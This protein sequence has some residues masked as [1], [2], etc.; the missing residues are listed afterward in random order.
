MKI[1]QGYIGNSSSTSYYVITNCNQETDG[2]GGSVAQFKSKFYP[3]YTWNSFARCEMEFKHS[4]TGAQRYVSFEYCRKSVDGSVANP[5]TDISQFG[6]WTA[7]NLVDLI[8]LGIGSHVIEGSAYGSGS[9]VT[10]E[11]I[12]N[13]DPEKWDVVIWVY[14]LQA[15]ASVYAQDAVALRNVTVTS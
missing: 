14:T 7:I 10:I 1:K 6:P 9:G 12:D 3:A 13:A 4:G 11:I 15:V 2:T 8:A 5:W